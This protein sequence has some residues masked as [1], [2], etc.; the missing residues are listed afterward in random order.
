ME[1]KR[2]K[3]GN[4]LSTLDAVSEILK[5]VLSANVRQQASNKLR[6]VNG[7]ICIVIYKEKL[8]S[9]YAIQHCIQGGPIKTVPFVF[10]CSIR[11]G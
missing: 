2:E 9:A 8:L 4:D 5:I 1:L 7:R 10:R 3:C 6:H 11:T